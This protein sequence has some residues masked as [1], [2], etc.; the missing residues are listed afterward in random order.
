MRRRDLTV[1]K[2]V[3]TADP[4]THCRRLEVTLKPRE[5]MRHALA[6]TPPCCPLLTKTVALLLSST[7]RHCETAQRA[8]VPAR[9]MPEDLLRQEQ[10]RR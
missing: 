9:G 8:G 4:R 3:R 7:R 1:P 6:A 5:R 10:Q 2:P